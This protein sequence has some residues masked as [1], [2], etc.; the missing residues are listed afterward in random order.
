MKMKYLYLIIALGTLVACKKEFD[1]RANEN[2][3]I[4]EHAYVRFFAGSLAATGNFIM[5]DN[6]RLN[7]TPL[8]MGGVFPGAATITAFATVKAGSKTVTIRDTAATTVQTPVTFSQNFL[9]GSYY[10]I[11]SH[12]TSNAVKALVAIDNIVIPTDNTAS[13]KFVNI[14][15]SSGTIPNV[16]LYSRRKGANLA[17]NI[18][19][20]GSSA[21]ASHFSGVQDTLDVRA[22]GTTTNLATF[23]A[24]TFIRNR[25]Y[26]VVFRGRYEATSGTMARGLNI[27]ATY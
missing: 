9:A 2:N 1:G 24:F 27:I 20:L 12:D 15:F 4:V 8:A 18:G 5:I 6:E 10:T 16:D 3:N 7:G 25:S 14:I 19:R 13:I 11:Y 23:N 26:S 17:T 22:T 21:F